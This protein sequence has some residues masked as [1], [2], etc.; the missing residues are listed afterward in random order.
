MVSRFVNSLSGIERAMKG[1]PGS[2]KW[3]MPAAWIQFHVNIT[4]LEILLYRQKLWASLS[5]NKI[6]HNRAEDINEL[7]HLVWDLSHCI[8]AWISAASSSILSLSHLP[9]L[10]CMIDYRYSKVLK[11]YWVPT[12]SNFRLWNFLFFRL[13]PLLKLPLSTNIYRLNKLEHSLY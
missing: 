9:T 1:S 11:V 2:A 8:L 6:K 4:P 13:T 3:S 12:M 5:Q 10:L 7:Q